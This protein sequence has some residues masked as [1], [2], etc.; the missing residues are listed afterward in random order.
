VLTWDLDWRYIEKLLYYQTTDWEAHRAVSDP[1]LM[2]GLRPG[3]Y[4]FPD[5]HIV[6]VN[7]L[8]VRGPERSVQKP[9]GVFR[10]IC[11]GGSNVY[12]AELND[13]E[14]WPALLEQRLNESCPG[15]F[16]VWNMGV[17][18]YVGSQIAR[19]ARQAGEQ[20][21]PDLLIL[22]LS[23]RGGRAFLW[24]AP[25]EPY[26]DAAPWMWQKLL[27]EY[28]LKQPFFLSYSSRIWLARHWRTF[29]FGFLA[30]KAAQEDFHH[31]TDDFHEHETENI[32]SIR[33]FL[34]DEVGKVCVFQCPAKRCR[35]LD[36]SGYMEGS[37]APL[38]SLN[39]DD[40]PDEYR[41]IHPPAYVMEWYADSVAGWLAENGLIPAEC[42]IGEAVRE[43]RDCI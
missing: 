35:E 26:F 21:D 36:I 14:T 11:L 12:G 4:E 27:P 38:F 16:E 43:E 23:N 13:E 29:R 19:R 1:R 40:L 25:V 15:R 9:E 22:A 39:A 31:W 30:I 41:L 32:Y 37:D 18:A 3:R 2:Y 8:G 28:Y 17:C 5:G 7:A 33:N 6:N 24:G 10:I 42:G 20:Y 34:A